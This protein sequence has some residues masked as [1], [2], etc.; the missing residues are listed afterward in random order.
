MKL[1]LICPV[2]SNLWTSKS[3]NNPYYDTCSTFM[4]FKLA[5]IGGREP[6]LQ[7]GQ[8]EF[9]S[10]YLREHLLHLLADTALKALVMTGARIRAPEQ[11]GEIK[12]SP[13]D[14]HTL[15]KCWVRRGYTL[16]KK[17]K[18]HGLS[19]SKTQWLHSPWSPTFNW[20]SNV[21]VYRFMT[22]RKEVEML[23]TF[24]ISES[25]SSDVCN[26]TWP[27]TTPKSSAIETWM[28]VT[29]GQRVVAVFSAK[30]NLSLRPMSINSHQILG[31]TMLRNAG[32]VGFFCNSKYT[33]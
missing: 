22:L 23:M 3:S 15:G 27:E 9:Q 14:A 33:S 16:S 21:P 13:P 12:M 29:R 1:G 20:K 25:R 7:E 8:R 5:E 6:G 4:C 26:S 28:E 32:K 11:R 17:V 19:D 18:V 10:S 24:W 31:Q 30:A 2:K